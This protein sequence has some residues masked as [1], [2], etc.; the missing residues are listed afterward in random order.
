MQWMLS[1]W[2][3]AS[4]CNNVVEPTNKRNT[5]GFVALFYADNEDTDR[6]EGPVSSAFSSERTQVLQASARQA[7]SK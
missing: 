2:W 5:I 4:S 1:P 7:S 3:L 6:R